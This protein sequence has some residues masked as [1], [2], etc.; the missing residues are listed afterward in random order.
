MAARDTQTKLCVRCGEVQLASYFYRQSGSKDGLR[1]WCKKCMN[2][3]AAQWHRE[4]PDKAREKRRNW[5]IKQ[6][7]EYKLAASRRDRDGRRQ[8]YEKRYPERK[9]AK[10]IVYN[11]I[12][13]GDL[14]R[15][16]C[17][18][19]GSEKAQ[20][21]HED[22]DKP[23]DVIWFCQICHKKHHRGT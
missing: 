5:A 4:N 11:A 8:R 19:C 18:E 23:L 6:S 3:R 14:V 2:E 1:S 17:S 20:A 22:Y 21:H 9:R 7:P 10:D 12:R 15:G 16:P 13:R